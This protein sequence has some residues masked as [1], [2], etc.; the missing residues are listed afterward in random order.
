M[1]LQIA[2]PTFAY[3][4]DV[5]KLENEN[6]FKNSVQKFLTNDTIIKAG[7]T[8]QNDI[9]LLCKYLGLKD[10]EIHN[11]VDISHHYKRFNKNNPTTNGL[12]SI[13]EYIYSKY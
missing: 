12:A 8:V 11:I 6:E 4:F 1:I 3:V 2:T 13:T 7:H 5:P 10:F 9:K